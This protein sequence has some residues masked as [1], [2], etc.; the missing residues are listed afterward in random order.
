MKL[1]LVLLSFLLVSVISSDVYAQSVPDWVKNTAGWWA[2]DAISETE[3]VNAIEFLVNEKV[4]QV[5]TL[6][7][8]ESSQSVP[9]WVKNTAGWWATDAISETEFVNAI[10]FLVNIG[11]ISVQSTDSDCVNSLKQIF[12]DKNEI[13][14]ICE[15]HNLKETDEIIP[16]TFDLN[17]NSKGFIGDDFNPEKPSD[18][19]RILMV[20]GSTMFGAE[21]SSVNTTV[22][23]ILQKMMDYHNPDMNIN[24][25]NAGISGANSIGEL[26][27]ISTK[28]VKYNPDIVIVY[29]GWNDISADYP[30]ALIKS[31]WT[32]M[33]Q[34][35]IENNFDVMIFLQPLAGFGEKTLTE[36][37]KVNALT[38]QDH[39]GF[40]LL[41]SKPTYDYLSRE[42]LSLN[43]ICPTYDHRNVFDNVQ[44]PIYW[45]QGHTLDV[46]NFILADSFLEKLHSQNKYGFNYNSKFV[47]VISKYNSEPIA[48]FLLSELGL[49]VDYSDVERMDESTLGYHKGAYFRLKGLVGGSEN[50]LVGKDL[51]DTDLSKINISEQDLTGANL[52]GKDLRDIDLSNTI[53]RN[54]NLSNTN[55]EGKSFQGLDIRGVNFSGA[56]MKN[57]DLRGASISKT[58]Q[59]GGVDCGDP[60]PILN[61][62][63]NFRCTDTIVTNES[64][65]TN[66]SNADME[67]AKFGNLDSNEYY[68]A[69]YFV[70]FTNVNLNNAEFDGINFTGADFGNAKLNN[71]K[72]IDGVI[73]SSNFKNTEMNNFSI[74]NVWFQNVSFENSSLRNGV[75]SYSTWADVSI[76]NADLNETNF[77]EVATVSE[78]DL[79]C[80]NNSVCE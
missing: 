54:S 39:N 56:N 57:V 38:G 17:F 28:L 35:G 46:G 58:I 29:D 78:N 76:H 1:I 5:N 26:E 48:S 15:E 9:D 66:F 13:T 25:I 11:I 8:S 6:D 77:V 33:C 71:V 31:N 44:G 14:R 59:L 64:F 3:F 2:T 62:Y 18:E 24:V 20:G 75:I 79:S 50:I 67:Y 80:I 32:Q 53:I 52:S 60:D 12:N 47:D 37:E 63:K 69:F 10:E 72:I 23:G 43:N 45:D 74:E 61:Y 36:Q 73:I 16:Y 49:V 19:F 40:Q 34:V 22:P 4:I 21:S 27:L 68:D 55:L 7:S 41:Q 70:D 30:V 42:L 51:R 65:R